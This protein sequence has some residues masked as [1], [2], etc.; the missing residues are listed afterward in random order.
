MRD[1]LSFIGFFLFFSSLI[2]AQELDC[3]V[4]V[5]ADQISVSNNQIFKTLENSL[6]EFVNQTQWT[7]IEFQDHERIKCGMTIIITEQPSP[8][9]FSANIQIQASRPVFNATYYAPIL[10]YKDNS[11][12]FSYT[13]FQPIN[14][15]PNGFESDLVS[16]VSFY[17]Y[18][19]LGLYADT[20]TLN[21]GETF[22]TSALNIANQ[23]QQSGGSGWSNSRSEI[24]RFTII[25]RIQS[26]SGSTY[27]NLMYKYH[28]LV[29]D[30]F[31]RNSKG[32]TKNLVRYLKELENLYELERSNNNMLVR[33]FLDAKSDEIVNIFR[34]NRG[35]QTKELVKMLK[36]IASNN[37]KKW[38]QIYEN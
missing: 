26:T 33:F 10:N 21:G 25:D 15:N 14:Y 34:K 13:E 22:L 1:H 20:F 31:E 27:R 8:N 5:N 17:S 37:S 24:N 3:S 28:Y 4:T 30:V 11:F 7:N 23:A 38:K 6:T 18:L 35:V 12:N 2:Y 29:M 19:I 36:K 16:V 9:S 32:A